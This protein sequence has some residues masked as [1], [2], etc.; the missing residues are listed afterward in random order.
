MNL[1]FRDSHG[2]KRL[3]ASDLRFKEEVWE[4]IQKFLNDHNFK[5][6]YT[7]MW[8]VD[9]YTW[10]DVGSHTEFFC[11]DANLISMSLWRK[12]LWKRRQCSRPV[13]SPDFTIVNNSEK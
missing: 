10:Y 6:Y 13:R 8:Y 9:G 12:N 2:K 7:R 5:S 11:V 4:H 1:Y 3:I